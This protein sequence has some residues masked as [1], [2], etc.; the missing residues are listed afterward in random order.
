MATNRIPAVPV[1]RNAAGRASRMGMACSN[2]QI[3]RVM[4]DKVRPVKA[5][6]IGDVF[7]AK[8]RY[9]R[10]TNHIVGELESRCARTQ[11]AGMKMAGNM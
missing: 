9:G 8:L 1:M 5:N 7:C 10:A 6:W 2:V 4:I 3:A 11:A